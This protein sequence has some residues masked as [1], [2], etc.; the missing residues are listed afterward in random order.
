MATTEF[1]VAL[2]HVQ[3]YQPDIAE[4]GIADFD[5]QLQ[6]AEDDVIRQVREEWWEDIAIQSDIK[7]LPRL[8]LLK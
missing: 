5:T 1:S 7:I 3:E 8:L 4:Y 2:S 6:H